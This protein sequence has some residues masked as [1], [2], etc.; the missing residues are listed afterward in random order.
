MLKMLRREYDEAF[1]RQ[2]QRL[3]ARAMYELLPSSCVLLCW[4]APNVWCHRR[5]VAEWFEGEL[6][7]VVREYGMERA[8]SLR[9]SEMPEKSSKVVKTNRQGGLF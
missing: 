7:I 1:A 4:E 3:S 5:A 9:Y 6:G 2:L 8:D